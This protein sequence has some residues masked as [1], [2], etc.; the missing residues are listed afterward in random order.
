MVINRKCV[1]LVMIQFKHALH[2]LCDGH[3]FLLKLVEMLSGN[4]YFFDHLPNFISLKVH[5]LMVKVSL[6]GNPIYL[7]LL[8]MKECGAIRP[9]LNCFIR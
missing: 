1:F 4:T 5:F 2:F 8:A 9:G 3:I 6:S 7:R